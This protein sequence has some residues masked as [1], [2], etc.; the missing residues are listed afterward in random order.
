MEFLRDI[1]LSKM[2][3]NAG[4]LDFLCANYV[5]RIIYQLKNSL[6]VSL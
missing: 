1:V 2:S 4:I 6:A 3:K 5:F